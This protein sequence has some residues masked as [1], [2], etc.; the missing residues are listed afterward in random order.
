MVTEAE[1][2]LKHTDRF[3][4]VPLFVCA[5]L[6]GFSKDFIIADTTLTLVRAST[7]Q[8]VHIAKAYTC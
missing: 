7:S 1:H 6:E 3:L 2:V 5:S 4:E 8:K